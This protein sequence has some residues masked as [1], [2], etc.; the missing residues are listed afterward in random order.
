MQ[1]PTLL[2]RLFSFLVAVVP[3]LATASPLLAAGA[4]ETAA[5]QTP[6]VTVVGQGELVAQPDQATINL[7]VQLY[8][9]NAQDA[10]AELQDRMSAVI[11]AIRDLG[12]PE[13]RIQTTNYSIFFER[14][15]QAP[16]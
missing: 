2:R 10:A 15:Y 3:L 7:G 16:M 6:T 12:V 9:E 4:P 11:A 13:S 1:Y 8:S 14:N 5:R